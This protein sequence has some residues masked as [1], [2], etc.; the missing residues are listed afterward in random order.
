MQF[1]ESKVNRDDKG[2][3]AEKSIS[4]LKAEQTIELEDKENLKSQLLNLEEFD[5]DKILGEEFAGYKGQDAVEKLVKEKSGHIK[6]A[7]H[8]DDFGDID[9]L[10]G[11]ESMG[12][13]HIISRRE[14]QGIDVNDFLRDLSEVV[15]KGRFRKKN[16]R[17]NFEFMHGNKIAV[18]A[19][20]YKGHKMVY[21]LTAFKTRSKK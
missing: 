8:R 6:S 15:E 4:E 9:L 5:L 7:F 20:E 1:D 21:L 3:F 14:E 18:I 19:P 11:N 17:G 2:R 16:Q 13:C 12:L 10:W